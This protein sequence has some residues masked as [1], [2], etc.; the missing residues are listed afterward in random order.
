MSLGRHGRFWWLTRLESEQVH[1]R[2]SKGKISAAKPDQEA[3][4]SRLARGGGRATGLRSV[5]RP[6]KV[7]LRAGHPPKEACQAPPLLAP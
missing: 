5:A 3:L 4:L 2:V 7:G 1:K 6:Q